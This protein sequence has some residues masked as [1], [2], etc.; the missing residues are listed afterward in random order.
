MAPS[1]PEPIAD[2]VQQNA[3]VVRP[4]RSYA[5]KDEPLL[6]SRADRI[7]YLSPLSPDAYASSARIGN[8]SEWVRRRHRRSE[9]PCDGLGPGRSGSN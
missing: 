4:G 8:L 1:H 7:P 9:I 5:Q 2:V 6:A 3:H